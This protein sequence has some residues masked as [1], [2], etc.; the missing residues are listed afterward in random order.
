MKVSFDFDSTLDKPH[1][2]EYAKS[3][4]DNGFEV[5]IVTTRHSNETMNNDHYNDDLFEVAKECGINF[6]NIHFTDHQD[7]WQFLKDKGFIFHLDDD[8]HELRC[9]QRNIKGTM[10]ISSFG[11]PKWKHKC[12]KAIKNYETKI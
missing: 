12:Q 2:Q 4:V 5:W 6:N 8:W 7:K 11:N 3:L 9:I 10:A 1:I